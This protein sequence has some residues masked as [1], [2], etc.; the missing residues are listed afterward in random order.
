MTHLPNSLSVVLRIAL[1]IG[2]SVVDASKP[3]VFHGTIVY[4]VYSSHSQWV[5]ARD[6]WRRLDRFDDY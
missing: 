1:S 6:S 4:N 2:F 3:L 5:Q